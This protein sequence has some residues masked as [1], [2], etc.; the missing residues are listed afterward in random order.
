LF[1]NYRYLEKT[2]YSQRQGET[3]QLDLGM[4]SPTLKEDSPYTTLLWNELSRNENAESADIVHD[5]IT[6]KALS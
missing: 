6:S 1:H 5:E 2:R 4:L 3:Q